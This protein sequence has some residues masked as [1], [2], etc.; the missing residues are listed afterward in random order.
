MSTT[1]TFEKPPVVELVLGAQ[2]SPLTK[3]TAGHF[4]LFWKELG[5]D[6]VKPS[7]GPLI[8][9][10]FESF[11]GPRWSPPTGV[12]IA[13]QPLRLP[14]RFLV[15]HRSKDRLIQIQATRFHFNWRKR[16]H[17]YPSY[18]N[19]IS[20]FETAFARFTEFVDKHELGKIALNQWELTY[21]D[22]FPQGEYWENPA[23]WSRFLPGLFGNLFP[24][25][26]LELLLEY[27]GAEWSYEITPK[28]GRLYIDARP[29]LWGEE[30]QVSLLLQMTARGPVG[31]DG[32]ASLREG[33]DLG[34]DAAV[35]VFLR[36]VD[37]NTKKQWGM[38]L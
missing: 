19:L 21:I 29:G 38:K 5:P 31:K 9:D 7:D 36:V 14:G 32:V 4:G 11:D 6:W 3:L 26:G 35:G 37:E 18:K 13:I 12:S 22:S 1:P 17:F 20:E 16:D 28:R 24:T 10:H 2:F 34:H 8:E 25:N 23:D 30:K 27:R 15:E 33:L